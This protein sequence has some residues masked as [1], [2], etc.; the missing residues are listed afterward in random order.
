MFV[1]FHLQGQ[2][3]GFRE[4][5]NSFFGDKERSI[6]S[7]C[8]ARQ[9]KGLTDGDEKLNMC[10]C[11]AGRFKLQ[12]RFWNM[13]SHTRSGKV[14]RQESVKISST[15]TCNLIQRLQQT[16]LWGESFILHLYNS[17][18]NIQRPSID[19]TCFIRTT[20][21]TWSQLLSVK[22]FRGKGPQ[23]SLLICISMEIL[24]GFIKFDWCTGAGCPVKLNIKLRCCMTHFQG[25]VSS[26]S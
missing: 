9:A 17:G 7:R 23:I 13:Y 26:L 14:W 20:N 2:S 1:S 24:K 10:N 12:E 22:Y 8:R 25:S 4:C 18:E 11:I 3:A 15:G 19:V 16:D 21:T 5:V 6:P